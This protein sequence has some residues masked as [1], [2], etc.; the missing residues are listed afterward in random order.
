MIRSV[1]EK[2]KKNS[3]VYFGKAVINI[4]KEERILL[5]GRK[6]GLVVGEL[7]SRSKGCGFKSRHIQNTRWKWVKPCQDQFLQPI[8]VHSWKK[9]IG[10]A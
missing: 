3:K 4:S 2:S 8:L 5:M 10:I 6:S 1:L 7:V 9:D